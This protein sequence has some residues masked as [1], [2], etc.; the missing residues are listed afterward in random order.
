M[1]HFSYIMIK[2]SVLLNATSAEKIGFLN[3]DLIW[4]V[5]ALGPVAPARRKKAWCKPYA[6]LCNIQLY[7]KYLHLLHQ[8][9][10]P[11]GTTMPSV[12]DAR[13]RWHILP[14]L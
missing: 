12:D 2:L 6:G 14:Q 8:L 3:A 11:S 9:K 4:L 13:P 7:D 1:L 5:T 10:L